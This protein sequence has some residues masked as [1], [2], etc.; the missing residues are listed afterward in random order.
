[1]ECDSPF[2]LTCCHL[3]AIPPSD[4]QRTQPSLWLSALGGFGERHGTLPGCE[5]TVICGRT[6]PLAAAGT[7]TSGELPATLA[8]PSG[9]LTG[10]LPCRGASGAL[11][12]SGGA[13]PRPSCYNNCG[14]RRRG[15]VSLAV[16]GRWK[17]ARAWHLFSI[18]AALRVTFRAGAGKPTYLPGYRL[19]KFLS[20]SPAGA[21]ARLYR[22]RTTCCSACVLAYGAERR[23]AARALARNATQQERTLLFGAVSGEGNCAA[24]D[25]GFSSCCWRHLAREQASFARLAAAPAHWQPVLCACCPSGGTWRAVR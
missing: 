9:V 7:L 17:D 14:I 2:K 21:C 15:C 19:L 6:L 12:S 1:V 22:A 16:A 25:I 3:H 24:S 18:G 13:T 5:L 4:I 23:Q 10:R 20:C 11:P 8:L